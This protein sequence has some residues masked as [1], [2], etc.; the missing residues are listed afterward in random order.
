M[1]RTGKVF[2][3]LLAAHALLGISSYLGIPFLE[4]IGGYAVLLPFFSASLFHN[5]RCWHG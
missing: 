5:T 1:R 2:G 4:T 3:V